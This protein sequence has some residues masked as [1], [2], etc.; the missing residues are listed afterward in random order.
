MDANY[1]GST[2]TRIKDGG[3]RT[4]DEEPG[5]PP[6]SPAPGLWPGFFIYRVG[7]IL[8]SDLPETEASLIF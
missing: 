2:K 5:S 3:R 7:F 8:S 1:Y 4:V 6:A